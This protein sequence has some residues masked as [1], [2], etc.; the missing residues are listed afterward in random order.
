MSYPGSAT[1]VMEAEDRKPQSDEAHSAFR[2]PQGVGAS[3]DGE[4][5]TTS[6]FEIPQGLAVSRAAGSEAET[7]SEFALPQ[8]LDVP[9]A[10]PAESEGSAFS[11]PSTYS[12]WT[13]PSAFT[14]AS[15][16]PLVSLTKDVP[17]QDRMRAMLRMPV[18][19]RP[20][21]ETVQRHDD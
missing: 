12:A 8:G 2:P 15:G 21:P 1:Q 20:A 10:P 13:A 3:A 17:W 5:S 7:T 19:E 6:E 9:A 4:S 16:I 14:P 11:T 18:A